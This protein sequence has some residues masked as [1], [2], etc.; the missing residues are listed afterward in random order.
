MCYGTRKSLLEIKMTLERLG[1]FCP[2]YLLTFIPTPGGFRWTDQ[3]SVGSGSRRRDTQF[4]R[5]LTRWERS[6]IKQVPGGYRG[7]WNKCRVLLRWSEEKF[8]QNSLPYNERQSLLLRLTTW[9]YVAQIVALLSFSIK[10][11]SVRYTIFGSKI[12]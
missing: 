9:F 12:N 5:G 2:C 3:S 1:T 11:P 10:T 6:K 4:E 8:R 7:Y